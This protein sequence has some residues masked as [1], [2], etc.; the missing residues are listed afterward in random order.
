MNKYDDTPRTLGAYTSKRLLSVIL[1]RG[2]RLYAWSGPDLY[3]IRRELGVLEN[4]PEKLVI[5]LHTAKGVVVLMKIDG[6]FKRIRLD[7]EQE[8]DIRKILA[9]SIN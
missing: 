3:P 4:A 7:A 5:L 9:A 2:A 6:L 8:I 1:E